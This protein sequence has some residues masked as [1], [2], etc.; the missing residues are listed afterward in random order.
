MDSSD[1]TTVWCSCGLTV[2]CKNAERADAAADHLA[3]VAADFLDSL[4]PAFT[5]AV[6]AA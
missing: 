1:R 5:A 6:A 2:H 4:S 3:A